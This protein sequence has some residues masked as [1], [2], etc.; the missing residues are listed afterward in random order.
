[1]CW[2]HIMVCPRPFPGGVLTSPGEFFTTGQST[3][4]RESGGLWPATSLAFYRRVMVAT[5]LTLVS[6]LGFTLL[7]DGAAL[8][9]T[10]E[11]G[12][13]VP[14]LRQPR[15]HRLSLWHPSLLPP[16]TPG[17]KGSSTVAITGSGLG[18]GLLGMTFSY[19]PL[20]VLESEIGVGLGYTGGS[21]Q[22]CRGGT[23]LGLDPFRRRRGCSTVRFRPRPS[24]ATM[25]GSVTSGQ[26]LI[27]LGSR[28]GQG[29]IWSSSLA[30]RWHL[31]NLESQSVPSTPCPRFT[32]QDHAPSRLPESFTS[33]QCVHA[34][35]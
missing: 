34:S 19:L 10:A 23:R 13:S 25:M 3:S 30:A 33:G 9:G 24:N 17:E 21:S 8:A 29:A 18:G 32:W 14:R 20:P 31:Q 35:A 27:S 16:T 2:A 15:A 1:M 22:P 11:A 4:C 6:L 26:F 5:R 7:A 12:G 28:S